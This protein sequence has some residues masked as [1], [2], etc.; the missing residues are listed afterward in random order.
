[1]C[2]VDFPPLDVSTPF[3]TTQSFP[4]SITIPTTDYITINKVTNGFKVAVF[5]KEYVF[6]SIENLNKFLEKELGDVQKL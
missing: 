4:G 2:L 6:E 3:D 1:M 5:G